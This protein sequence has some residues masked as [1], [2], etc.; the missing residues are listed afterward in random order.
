M[1]DIL[2]AAQLGLIDINEARNELG[3][4]PASDEQK[5]IWEKNMNKIITKEKPTNSENV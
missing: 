2:K 4:N 1:A 3:L 5:I